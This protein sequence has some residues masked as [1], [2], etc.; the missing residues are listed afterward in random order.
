M[1]NI[2][3][4]DK[5][6]FEN[7]NINERNKLEIYMESD[8]GRLDAM[9]AFLDKIM[10]PIRRKLNSILNP[11]KIDDY[12]LVSKGDI[13]KVRYIHYATATLK[14]LIDVKGRKE[15]SDVAKDLD[16]IYNYIKSYTKKWQKAYVLMMNGSEAGYLAFSYYASNVHTWVES[17][18]ILLVY[19]L[20]NTD[21]KKHILFSEFIPSILK[22]FKEGIFSK[23]YTES[24]EQLSK[25]TVKESVIGTTMIAVG[26][27]VAFAFA[28]RMI[29]FYVYY[30]RTQLADYFEQQSTF[31]KIHASEVKKRKDLSPE[32]KQSILESQKKWAE[33]LHNL[34]ELIV[35][36]SIEAMKKAKEEEKNVNIDINPT[37]INTDDNNRIDFF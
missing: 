20:N 7:F 11:S 29:V 3:K 25:K 8:N 13:T 15:I 27:I 35:V 17:V 6:I 18:C 34:S 12:I 28:L 4:L 5:I 16:S 2:E 37:N 26:A 10:D 1:T 36:D 31:L 21:P 14:L 33:R 22:D 9:K 24:I 23:Y 30:S 32:E 19:Y